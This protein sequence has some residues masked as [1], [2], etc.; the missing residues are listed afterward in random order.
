[1]SVKVHINDLSGVLSGYW[2]SLYA[3][4]HLCDNLHFAWKN[5][6]PRDGAYQWERQSKETLRVKGYITG[7]R[8]KNDKKINSACVENSQKPHLEQGGEKA[9]QGTKE[10]WN[11]RF[12][13]YLAVGDIEHQKKKS[14]TMRGSIQQLFTSPAVS[15]TERLMWREVQ[16][17]YWKPN[18]LP[19]PEILGR[20]LQPGAGGS[21]AAWAHSS[22][23]KQSD[24]E[25]CKGGSKNAIYSYLTNCSPNDIPLIQM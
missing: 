7:S 11:S 6:P 10:I 25:Q 13:L 5:S 23:A 2:L 21:R 14:G 18:T 3:L 4:V 12:Y 15:R 17:E 24:I 20:I 1:M 22:P 9:N 16:Q 8:V 19:P